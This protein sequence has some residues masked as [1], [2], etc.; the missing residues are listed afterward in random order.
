MRL[1]GD[2]QDGLHPG[3][4][5]RGAPSAVPLLREGLRQTLAGAV[6][7]RGRELRPGATLDRPGEHDDAPGA[8]ATP[9]FVWLL[10]QP[11]APMSALGPEIELK[12]LLMSP[13]TL[14]KGLLERIERE[15]RNAQAGLPAAKVVAYAEQQGVDLIVTGSHGKK[16]LKLL[17]GSVAS[18]ILHKA[19]CDVFVHRIH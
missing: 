18:G 14:H 17:L 10:C 9:L 3:V 5:G 12:H 2:R 16:G 8:E 1:G 7:G 19:V 4:Q 15:I 13:F 6:H 11:A